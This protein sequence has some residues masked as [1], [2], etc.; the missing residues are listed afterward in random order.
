MKAPPT[1]VLKSFFVDRLFSYL[2]GL[3]AKPLGFIH[4]IMRILSKYNLSN[5]L[6]DYIKDGTLQ[7]ERTWKNLVIEKISKHQID[8]WHEGSM[9]KAELSNYRRIHNKIE[10]LHLWHVAKRAP[11]YIR[12][13]T[14]LVN[15]ICGNVP[16][17]LMNAVIDEDVYFKCRVCEK[18][19]S[20]VPRHFIKRK[21][22][23][24]PDLRDWGDDRANN[25]DYDVIMKM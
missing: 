17:A 6:T 20:N 13:V 16:K 11:I 19:F 1:T 8:I 25:G 7:S 9:E 15:I 24:S 18:T 14:T 12:E 3:V 21:A 22:V 4:D 10:P 23:A 2:N 5:Y